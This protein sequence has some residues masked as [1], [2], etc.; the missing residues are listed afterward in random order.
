MNISISQR[1]K[2]N[3]LSI[4]NKNGQTLVEYA[5]IIAIISVTAISTLLVMGGQV[6]GVFS[7][8]TSQTALAQTGGP[9]TTAA[10]PGR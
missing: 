7:T 4:N 5:L 6:K 9:V 8:I 10:P 1:T 2:H 3:L